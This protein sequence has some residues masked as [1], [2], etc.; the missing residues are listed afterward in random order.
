MGRRSFSNALW[1]C[2][3]SLACG[4]LPAAETATPVAPG[5]SAVGVRQ[6][7][8]AA[9]MQELDQRFLALAKALEKTE[10]ERAERLLKAF[11]E[12]KSTLIEPRMRQIVALLDG[13]QLENAGHEEAK[14]LEDVRRLIS[15]LLKE[16]DER[17][18]D[19]EEIERLKKWHQQITM[20]V[21]DEQAQKAESRK[22]DQT[23]DALD[24]LA[25][26]IAAVEELLKREKELL[27]QTVVTA[28][29]GVTG[30]TQLAANQERIRRDTE[31]VN[32]EISKARQAAESGTAS[33]KP[34]P[35]ADL[36][37]GPG[38]KPLAEAAK[39]QKSAEEHLAA[40]QAKSARTA[41]EQAVK[42]LEKALDELKKEEE[43]LKSPPPDALDK[44]AEKQE[45]L[46]KKTESLNDQIAKAAQAGKPGEGACSAC[47][48]CLGGACESMASAASSLK[49]KSPGAAAA[50]Q[51]KAED[52]LNEAKKEV[53]KRL[54]ELGEKP[55]DEALERL[56]TI[57]TEMLARQQ[58]VTTQTSEFH[59]ERQGAQ[60]ELRR[61]ERITIRRLSQ[62]ESELAEMAGKAL[63]LIEEDGTTI[64]FPV[65]VSDMQE[66]LMQIS[67]RIEKQETG[68]TTQTMQKEVEKTLEELIEALKVA[69][70]GGGGGGKG[71]GNCKPCLL[72]N[73]AEL[74]LLRQLQLRINRRT[75]DFQNARPQGDLDQPRQKEVQRIA[76]LQ[77][78]VATMVREILSR[79]QEAAGGGLQFPGVELLNLTE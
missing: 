33:A 36:P 79:Q 44:L 65:I 73:T 1:V 76:G 42:E 39:Q 6:E 53:E 47:S 25:K 19:R 11:E 3:V 74:K 58:P 16:A 77:R 49:K 72:P 48:K 41:E 50:E 13:A 21:R 23:K 15:I 32:S 10:P 75:V 62:E 56:E 45:A 17:E 51:K 63:K 59:Q 68:E 40:T 8:V 29:E 54:A 5:P 67:N 78:N 52:Q 2:A 12:S 28:A 70:K 37:P 57:F 71:G 55:E 43:R 34:A 18:K 14:I 24:T 61:A 26:Q 69:R 35:A 27:R 66:S 4:F 38:Q 9:M 60:G 31:F 46:A 22:L 7:R 30:L 20:M 64:S